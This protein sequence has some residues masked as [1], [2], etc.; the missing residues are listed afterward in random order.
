M[1][2]FSDVS[3]QKINKALYG[4][5]KQK[6]YC[7]YCGNPITQQLQG[8]RLR[9]YC[10]RC[11]I[12]YYENPLP[13]ASTI[14]LNE[15]R[16]VLLVK[17]KKDPYQ[18]KWCLPIGFAES[19]EDMREAA[20]RE[21]EEEAGVQGEIIRLI[22][23]DTVENYFYGSLAI[24]TYE[25]RMIG[26]TIK[27]GDDASDAA[28]YPIMGLPELAWPSNHKAIN[29][30]IELYRDTWAMI[31]S[32]RQLYPEINSLD[33]ISRV[34]GGQQRFLS[35]MMVKML[36]RDEKEMSLKWADELKNK[37]PSLNQY[38]EVLIHS[39]RKILH[40][41]QNQLQ[42]NIE[43]ASYLEFVET[44]REL[45][46]ILLPLPELLTAIAL[47][48]KSI[49]K[50]VISKRI[51]ASPLEMYTILEL[52]NRIVFIYDRILYYLTKGYSE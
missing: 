11:N 19:G 34:E 45:K 12:I 13:V 47:S 46:K 28:Y 2:L 31:D 51:L 16:E 49:W 36:N 3:G 29:I 43:I 39:N 22:D 37:I 14:V 17:R 15:A 26:G 10:P 32:Y 8:D 7:S 25:V 38:L 21:L 1:M 48:R 52:N 4:M 23:V 18:G 9:D 33:I 6:K 50:H 5:K 24:V 27:P 40:T 30:Y 44:G 20:L 35:D 42:G 41:V